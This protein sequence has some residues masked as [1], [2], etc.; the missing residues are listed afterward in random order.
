[1]SKYELYPDNE[2]LIGI[3]RL[4]FNLY[5]ITS[6]VLF[7]A[8]MLLGLT[9]RLSQATW[10]TIDA[11]MFYKILT[12]HGAGMVGTMGAA[13]TAVMW[14]FLRKYVR[15]HTWAFL[16]NFVFFLLGALCI[17]AAVFVGDYAG[18]WTFLY[19]LPTMSMNLW[20]NGSAALFMGGYL[21]IGVGMLIFYLDAAAGI[22]KVYGN[23][24][25]ALGVQWLFKGTVPADHP[26]AV[27]AS[28]MVI[29]ANGIGILVGAVILV[30]Y[31]LNIFNPELQI[32]AL[33]AKNMIYWFGHMY[34]NATIY[35]GVIAVYELLSRYSGRAY[36][37]SRPFIW[38]WTVSC[39]FVIIVYPHHLLMDS[40]QPNWMQIMGQIVSHGAGFPVFL[41]TTFG[42]L[43]N[44]YRSGMKWK[45]P[46]ALLILSIFGWAAGIVP[47]MLDGTIAVNK[48][49]HNTQWVPGHFHFYLLLGVLPMVLGL[50]YHVVSRNLS[51]SSRNLGSKVA[52]PLYLIGGLTFTWAFLWAGSISVPRR[53][54][55]HVPM[56][57]TTDQM[58]S[59]GA[60]LVIVGTTIFAGRIIGGLIKS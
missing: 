37:I 52:F 48:L 12:M 58:G 59:V 34:I 5:I 16:T 45:M 7:L 18:G 25:R 19:P 56:W 57:L 38:S 40:V 10:Y 42:A 21:L 28:S 39:I 32:D 26:K 8:M 30:V 6:F 23:L 14:Y 1:M 46:V 47:A 3:D 29:I 41:V 13:S 36:T 35:M 11:A 53:F 33:L 54:A 27:V 50:C 44:I 51:E 43:T 49:M 2:R 31:I 24:G 15:L 22:I 55:E 60:I 9:M 17:V 4:T 20:T